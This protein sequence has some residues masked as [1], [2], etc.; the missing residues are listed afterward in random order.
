[1]NQALA[2]AEPG[3]AELTAAAEPAS[4]RSTATADSAASA[5][6]IALA[7]PSTEQPVRE[8]PVPNTETP[9]FETRSLDRPNVDNLDVE[10]STVEPLNVA[11]SAFAPPSDTPTSDTP[12]GSETTAPMPIGFAANA[13]QTTSPDAA[14]VQVAGGPQAAGGPQVDMAAAR[15]T[16]GAS[17]VDPNVA[18]ASETT[19]MPSDNRPAMHPDNRPAMPS[20]NKPA[21]GPGSKP[22]MASD[23][24]PAMSSD[25]STAIHAEEN[26]SGLANG[27][28]LALPQSTR[29][30][31]EPLVGIDP[32][33][34]RVFEAPHGAAETHGADAVTFGDDVVLA[35]GQV[36]GS[37]EALGLLGHE[38]THVAMARE[39]GAGATPPIA[40]DPSSPALL[41]PSNM[42]DEEGL[43]RRVEARV[44]GAAQRLG[45]P[46]ASDAPALPETQAM[47]SAPQAFPGRAAAPPNGIPPNGAPSNGTPS[48]GAPANGSLPHGLQVNAG[49]SQNGASPNG[50]QAHAGTPANGTPPSGATQDDDRWG[51][52]PAPWEPLPTWMSSS[53]P[54][55]DSIG[56]LIPGWAASASTGTNGTNGSGGNS[57]SAFNA[58]ATAAAGPGAAAMAETGRELE[59]MPQAAPNPAPANQSS[60]VQPDLDALAQQVY[61]V[62]KRRLSAE[63]RRQRVR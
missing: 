11:S 61:A 48:N 19:A 39:G 14:G 17:Q 12:P 9:K 21:M 36:G 35:A 46:E 16:T 57:T 3:T 59:P 38:L 51:G 43:A 26:D 30:F 13:S 44:I 32:A 47:P 27:A 63:S 24:N 25:N 49:T 33:S 28:E 2:A 62:L 20:D 42:L 60:Q 55:A 34:V 8:S 4:A 10:A 40:R 54:S 29:K 5:E 56:A 15:S 1:M 22:A 37:P 41:R 50:L 31:L 52:L 7:A 45:G 23:K 58:A 18:L 53:S 6:S